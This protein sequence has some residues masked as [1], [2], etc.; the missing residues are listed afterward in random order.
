[1]TYI[2]TFIKDA[3]PVNLALQQEAIRDESFEDCFF[4]NID[5]YEDYP[6][7]DECAEEAIEHGFDKFVLLAPEDECDELDYVLKESYGSRFREVSATPEQFFR[8]REVGAAPAQPAAPQQAPQPKKPVE[9]A[10]NSAVSLLSC[11]VNYP[12]NWG[13]KTFRSQFKNGF[14]ALSQV[15]LQGQYLD[16]HHMIEMLKVF[17][18]KT[19]AADASNVFEK[20]GILSTFDPRQELSLKNCIEEIQRKTK[21]KISQANIYCNSIATPIKQV[22]L[23]DGSVVKLTF[24]SS[25]PGWNSGVNATVWKAL[26]ELSNDKKNAYKTL[27]KAKV[28]TDKVNK[29][30]EKD[31]KT[32]DKR[33][34]DP[35]DIKRLQDEIQSGWLRFVS[36]LID[37]VPVHMKNGYRAP[38]LDEK[39]ATD[40]MKKIN[41]AFKKLLPGIDKDIKAFS[42]VMEQGGLDLLYK[43]AAGIVDIAKIGKNDRKKTAKEKALTAE[44]E[45]AYNLVLTEQYKIIKEALGKG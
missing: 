11:D 8:M 19:I 39:Q 23:D 33:A 20:R 16:P 41:D 34:F 18:D 31:D 27:A 1:M 12:S 3:D 13:W 28:K 43:G 38:L 36:G 9:P 21:F 26:V 29:E 5:N 37:T 40:Y 42:D 24:F 15:K 2:L 10:V 32:S 4:K 14:L 6:V 25:T 22:T 35:D 45:S 44:Q 17:P 30:L 7:I